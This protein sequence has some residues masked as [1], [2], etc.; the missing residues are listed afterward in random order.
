MGE[1]HTFLGTRASVQ[2]TDP[3]LA[4]LKQLWLT[5]A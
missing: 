1:R 3:A 4:F 5:K 2:E